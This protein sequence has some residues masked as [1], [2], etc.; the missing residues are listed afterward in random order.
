M[1]TNTLYA[2]VEFQK[3]SMSLKTNISVSKPINDYPKHKNKSNIKKLKTVSETSPPQTNTPP[4]MLLQNYLPLFD[5][6][7]QRVSAPC[8]CRCYQ[9]WLKVHP[10]DPA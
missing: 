9:T 4:Q 2:K 7:G 3:A 6:N 1:G 10:A 8:W 5:R